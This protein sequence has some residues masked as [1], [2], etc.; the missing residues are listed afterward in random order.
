VLKGAEKCDAE[1]QGPTQTHMPLTRPSRQQPHLCGHAEGHACQLAVELR[2]DLRD[3]SSSSNSSGSRREAYAGQSMPVGWL[4]SWGLDKASHC[5][6]TGPGGCCYPT[7][8]LLPCMC[9]LSSSVFLLW[10]CSQYR[11]ADGC[12]LR[13]CRNPSFRCAYTQYVMCWS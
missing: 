5:Y 13:S 4:G 6:C 9:D 2:D 1:S 11:R 10:K 7:V 12:L 8:T 3:S